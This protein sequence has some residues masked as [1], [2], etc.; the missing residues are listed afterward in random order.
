MTGSSAEQLSPG[1]EHTVW[2]M[3]SVKQSPSWRVDARWKPLC[4]CMTVSGTL[5]TVNCIYIVCVYVF[6][7][8]HD[9]SLEEFDDE[10]LSE[11]TDD[12]GIGL[13]YDSDPYEKVRLTIT[14]TTILTAMYL[15]PVCH[16]YLSTVITHAILLISSNP[17]W[18]AV[19]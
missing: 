13:N 5:N 10:D 17:G 12:C 3:M 7:P 9:I 2:A 1:L 4:T 11:I 15:Q 19:D 14:T 6:R 8:S 16:H 18:S